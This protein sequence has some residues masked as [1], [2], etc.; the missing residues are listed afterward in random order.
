MLTVDLHPCG[1]DCDNT[2]GCDAVEG[3]AAICGHLLHLPGHAGG[4]H[5]H[6]APGQQAS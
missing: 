6:T 3:G 2:V 5:Q 1:V 4:L